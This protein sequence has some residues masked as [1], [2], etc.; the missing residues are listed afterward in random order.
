MH[1]VRD[2]VDVMHNTS[3]DIFEA[4]KR[5]ANEGDG[6]GRKD[7]MSV[8]CMSLALTWYCPLLDAGDRFI[9]DSSQG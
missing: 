1:R 7:I 9:L 3:L 8:L 2:M 5:S 6:L 4:T